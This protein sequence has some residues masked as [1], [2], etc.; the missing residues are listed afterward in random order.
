MHPSIRSLYKQF[1]VLTKHYPD[2]RTAAIK[3]LQHGFQQNSNLN[4]SDPVALQQAL[5]KGDFILKEVMAL[6]RLHKYR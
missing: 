3:K 1:L 4:V 5:N 6:I 2:G